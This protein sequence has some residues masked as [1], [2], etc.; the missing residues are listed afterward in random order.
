MSEQVVRMGLMWILAGLGAGW[1][2]E[3]LI[4]RR[5]YGLLADMGLGVGAGLL[6]G[7]A[8]MMLSGRPSGTLAMFIGAFVLASGVI[9]AQRLLL[10]RTPGAREH[11]AELRLRELRSA[12]AEE[13][14]T[15]S[16]L[17]RL[18]RGV[19]GR[20]AAQVLMR[21]AT[22]GIYL[23]RGVPLELQRAARV[24]RCATAPRS[25]R[26]CSRA[27][28]STRR[29]AGHLSRATSARRLEGRKRALQGRGFVGQWRSA[30]PGSIRS[31]ATIEAGCSG[32][33]VSTLSSIRAQA[34]IRPFVVRR[35]DPNQ[36][37][38]SA[39]S[40]TKCQPSPCVMT[41]ICRRPSMGDLFF[42][43]PASGARPIHTST[44]ARLTRRTRTTTVRHA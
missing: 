30:T 4:V 20:P 34:S 1:L 22:T 43:G 11:K 10:P 2:A 8:F 15:A 7:G 23:L 13:K 44:N 41:W 32:S 18:G 16:G 25:T 33:S 38:P 3:T 26:C 17:D 6:G 9:V 27:W 19:I 39:S 29:E 5:G 28:G 21:V 24:A 35:G 31:G 36:T 12:S 14:G 37:R 42:R 40:P